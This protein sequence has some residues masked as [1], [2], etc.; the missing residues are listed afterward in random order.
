MHSGIRRLA[1]FGAVIVVVLS[2]LALAK[3]FNI[4]LAFAKDLSLVAFLLLMVLWRV[5]F[6]RSLYS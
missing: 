1:I 5:L 4:G 3:Y 2:V 6:F